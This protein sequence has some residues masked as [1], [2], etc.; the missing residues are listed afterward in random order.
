MFVTALIWNFLLKWSYCSSWQQVCFL[1]FISRLNH[2]LG[3]VQDWY[4]SIIWIK[5]TEPYP[6]SNGGQ[7]LGALEVLPIPDR[8]INYY[9]FHYYYFFFLRMALTG[10][11]SVA[12]N[13]RRL[14]GWYCCYF[15]I[16]CKTKAKS[17]AKNEWCAQ[18]PKAGRNTQQTNCYDHTLS[19][20]VLDHGMHCHSL[21]YLLSISAISEISNVTTHKYDFTLVYILSGSLVL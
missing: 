14:N 21:N 7:N 8:Y 20:N 9:Y 16:H 3:I 11:R 15:L 1:Y 6:Q 17:E 2:S 10:P 18:H 12:I 5:V 4:K 13:R 19:N